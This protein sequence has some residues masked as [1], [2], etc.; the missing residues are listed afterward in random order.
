MTVGL[1]KVTVLTSCT[2]AKRCTTEPVPAEQ[3]YLGQHHVRLMRGVGAL[4]AVGVQVD[5]WIVSA[6]HGV[7]HGSAPVSSYEQTFHG[8]SAAERRQLAHALEIPSQ[9]VEVISTTSDLGIV[10]LG[11]DY[12]DACELSPEACP[13]GHTIVFCAASPALRM[14]QLRHTTLIPLK[15]QH[16]R[17]FNCGFV[18]LKGEVAGRLL[19]LLADGQFDEEEL[20]D[21]RLLSKLATASP[22]SAMSSPLALF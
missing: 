2:A 12:L 14:P 20:H 17:E 22:V 8:R 21:A 19:S 11:E 4:R 13:G 18:G 5:V 6:K 1:S 10:V 15:A 3:L 7:I 16:T 9:A